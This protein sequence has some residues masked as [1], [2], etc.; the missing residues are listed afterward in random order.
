MV[1]TGIE[2]GIG[3]GLEEDRLQGIEEAGDEEDPD[4]VGKRTPATR[5]RPTAE[6]EI[7]VFCYYFNINI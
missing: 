1:G 3:T 6:V 4:I 2:T 5:S 7:S